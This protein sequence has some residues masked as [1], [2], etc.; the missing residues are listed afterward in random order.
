M[1]PL[2]FCPWAVIT[3]AVLFAAFYGPAAAT[4]A[5]TLC[6][7]PNGSHGCYA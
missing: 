1:H 3:C 5:N 4:A 6:V 7:N 2:R